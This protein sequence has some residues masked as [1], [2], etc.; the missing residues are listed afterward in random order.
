M[1]RSKEI[2]DGAEENDIIRTHHRPGCDA[3]A[4]PTVQARIDRF[5]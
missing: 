4:G 2:V 1:K 5:R 3:V